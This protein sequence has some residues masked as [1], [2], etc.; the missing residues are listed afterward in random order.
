MNATWWAIAL[1]VAATVLTAVGALLLKLGAKRIHLEPSW[2]ILQR[3][4]RVIAAVFLYGIATLLGVIAYKGGE[5][6]A[7]YPL[8]SLAYLWTAVLAVIVLDEK[9][10]A[11]KIAALLLII[12]GIIIISF[13]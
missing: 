3:N 13:S 8:S 9:L 4:W 7:L 6:T 12:A 10:T 5:L 11:R 2:R 1:S